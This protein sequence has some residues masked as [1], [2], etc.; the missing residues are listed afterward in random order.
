MA[1]TIAAEPTA[2]TSPL[3]KDHGLWA[4][5]P[6]NVLPQNAI[7]HLQINQP[8]RILENI[9]RL[10]V[11]TV[12]EKFL[13][14]PVQELLRTEHP[15]LTMLGVQSLGAPLT[16]DQ[17]AEKIGLATDQPATLTLYPGLPPKSIL[18]SLPIKNHAAFE[19][20]CR[21]FLH[22]RHATL[23]GLADK[24]YVRLELGHP[25]FPELFVACSS[26]R[27]FL[28][29]D[30]SLLLLLYPDNSFPRLKDNPHF[31]SLFEQTQ[32]E[33]V[34][35]TF[36]PE[37]L[38][39]FLF[40]I[41]FFEYLP[42]QLL[43]QQRAKLLAKIPAQ[44]RQMI[45]QRLRIQYGVR[46]LEQAADYAECLITATYEELFNYVVTNL[47]SFNG[48]TFASKFD[49]G[50][51]Q[52]T[53]YLHSDQKHTGGGVQ[54]IPLSAVRTALARIPGEHH[55]LSVTGRTPKI[56]PSVH[57][58]SWLK[59]VRAGF[60]AKHLNLAFLETIEKLH[61]ETLH[62]QPIAAQVPWVITTRV[63]VNP[64]AAPA[65]HESLQLYFQDLLTLLSY[66]PNRTITIVP[67]RD[68]KLL[69]NSLRAE[70]GALLQNRELIRKTFSQP[71]PMQ[72]FLE[73]AYRLN[74]RERDRGVSELT[75][76]TAFITHG[77]LFGFNQHELVNR[78]IYYSRTLD[79]YTVFHRASRDA[80]WISGLELNATPRLA[81]GL[82]KLLDRVP[83]G[84]TSISVHRPLADLPKVLNWVQSLEELVH[85]DAEVYLKQARRLADGITNQA[86]LM[87]K[88][89]RMKFSPVVSSVNRDA[90][91]GELYCL[92]PGNLS[93]PR[94]KIAPA[95]MKLFAEFNRSAEDAGGFLCYTR[96]SEGQ[97]EASFLG[98]TE[99]FSKLIKTVGNAVHDQYLQDPAQRAELQNLLITDRDKNQKRL[100]EV[101]LRN[102][103]W[104][105]LPQLGAHGRVV[106]TKAQT[107]AKPQ[108]AIA[109]R[110]SQASAN[111]ID[112]TPYYNA[113]PNDCWHGGGTANNDL[114]SLPQGLREFAGV[115]FDVRGIV[116]LSGQSAVD[117]LSVRFP[118]EVKDIKIDRLCGQLHFLHA[119]GW[120]S[121]DGTKVGF[122]RVHYQ[123]GNTEEIPI[124]YGAHVRDWWTAP[125]AKPVTAS[126]VAWKGSNR[127]STASRVSLQLYK[128]TWKN[129]RPDVAIAKLDYVSTMSPSAP[130]LIGL[131]A[132]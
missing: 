78:R 131:T 103:S 104:E 105:F 18:V 6:A 54:P 1:R 70:Q 116:Q 91:S 59:R 24:P 3:L 28:T 47:K 63:A 48:V 121:S 10:A 128:T 85:H 102:P 118:N 97:A 33:D 5:P 98:N 51:K 84:A 106:K 125:D 40:Q 96:V 42:L 46:D 55:H 79:D 92:L 71:S 49:S 56:E 112:L 113:S 127:A 108:T 36:N 82:A 20:F 41:E 34:W 69:E 21:Q 53:L 43:S 100:N 111:L 35:L 115:K 122:F 73:T 25:K 132:E 17:I 7:V 19:A 66:P 15:L 31:A 117:Q 72:S 64:L 129:S 22:P 61:R 23:A 45:E 88:L 57:I 110:D 80:R 29:G 13:P 27:V 16:S 95:V 30:P 83:A 60:E 130:F 37:L 26:D 93:F 68:S 65:D 74:A 119:A 67:G 8:Q 87:G 50:F 109:A 77:G 52:T 101:V 39:P 90:D 76:E 114:A 81:P 2:E 9:E 94:P 11:S 107:D 123:D 99:G 89:E 126:E 75:W 124:V 14:P 38:K 32:G 12:P 58:T 120:V 4:G 62:P 86:E 44:Q